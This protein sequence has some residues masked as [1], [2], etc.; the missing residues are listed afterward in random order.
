ML[1][2][3][4]RLFFQVAAGLIPA[5]IFGGLISDRLKPSSPV[6][7]WALA[8][9]V[10][11][12]AL[13]LLVLEAEVLA[14]NAALTGT[15]NALTTWLVALVLVGLTASALGILVTPWFRPMIEGARSRGRRIAFWGLA[16]ASAALVVESALLLVTAV[17]AE[18]SFQ[19]LASTVSSSSNK[20]IAGQLLVAY[21]R[22]YQA[23]AEAGL[24]S[25]AQARNVHVC[26]S[27]RAFLDALEGALESLSPTVKPLPTDAQR[28]L[29]PG[30]PI[31]C[32]GLDTLPP[33]L[34]P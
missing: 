13:A 4:P 33:P 24:V 23:R 20:D 34:G 5:L 15:P 31:P 22:M 17:Q 1:Q 3:D 9:A 19:Q 25:K 11:S 32:H 30:K 7:R 27:D 6:R 28:V 21:D 14:I 26:L 29:I 12:F 16:A 10:L 18:Q 8:I 2:H